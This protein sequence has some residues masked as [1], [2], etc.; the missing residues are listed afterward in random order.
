M[1]VIFLD[2]DGVLATSKHQQQ[3]AATNKPLQDE[4]GAVFDPA[5]VD[6]LKRICDSTDA[7]IVVTST[8][9]IDLGAGGIRMMWADRNLPGKFRGVT[10]NIDPIRRGEEIAAWLAAHGNDCRYVIIDDCPFTDFFQ[11]EQLPHL[12]RVDERIGLDAETMEKVID[13][14]KN[15]I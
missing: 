13:Y 15:E 8:W 14:L 2:F 1:K 3:L 5:S 6:C 10:P 12:F 4:Y 11:E 9:K 7:D